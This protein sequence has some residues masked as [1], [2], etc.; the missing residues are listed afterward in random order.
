MD[1]LSRRNFE[2]FKSAYEQAFL[3]GISSWRGKGVIIFAFL[4]A[5]CTLLLLALSYTG[6]PWCLG[7]TGNKSA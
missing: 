3:L 1:T 4:F 5:L 6:I 2:F 7:E